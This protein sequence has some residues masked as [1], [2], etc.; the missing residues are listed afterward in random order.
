MNAKIKFNRPLPLVVSVPD[1]VYE[2][3]IDYGESTHAWH[4][5]VGRL[6]DREKRTITVGKSTREEL[7]LALRRGVELDQD[8]AAQTV[9]S[10]LVQQKRAEFVTAA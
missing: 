6:G 1:S 9:A 8:P 7:E 10:E 3:W 2:I 4:V 5:A